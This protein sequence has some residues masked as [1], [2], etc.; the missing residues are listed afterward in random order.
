M[1]ADLNLVFEN[2][3]K[4]NADESNIYKVNSIRVQILSF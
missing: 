2:A 1:A 4:Y 3:K